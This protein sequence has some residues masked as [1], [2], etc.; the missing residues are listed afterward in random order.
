MRQDKRLRF[1]TDQC[2]IADRSLQHTRWYGEVVAQKQPVTWTADGYTVTVF[3]SKFLAWYRY[4]SPTTP[5]PRPRVSWFTLE[6]W[7]P[8]RH[9]PHPGWFRLGPSFGRAIATLHADFIAKWSS[10][11]RRHL[12]AFDKSG[13]ILR[14]GT[15]QDLEQLYRVSQVPSSLQKIFLWLI[16]NHL[17]AHPQDIDIL[18]AE[19]QGQPIGCLVAGNCNELKESEYIAGAFHPDFTK[20]QAMTGLMQ[21]WFAR[22][23]ERGYTTVNLGLIDGPRNLLPTS[24]LGYSIF[25]TNFN[26]TRLW[27]PGNLWRVRLGRDL[28]SEASSSLPPG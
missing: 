4:F 25:K 15:K 22:S 24:T 13:V 8:T 20:H 17:A 23:Q 19:F 27:F 7:V 3:E 11:A 12:K 2:P 14:L 28:S 21:W 26:V 9:M 18:V 1:V 6:E 5:T 16:A 10:Q